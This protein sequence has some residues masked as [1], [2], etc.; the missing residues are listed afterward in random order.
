MQNRATHYRAAA[1]TYFKMGSVDSAYLF[2]NMY[3]DIRDSLYVDG[4]VNHLNELEKKFNSTEKEKQILRLRSEKDR[5]ALVA[6]K[7]QTSN[8]ILV[9]VSVSLLVTGVFYFIYSRRKVRQNLLN[10]QRRLKELEQANELKLTKA[11]LE[12][13]E[14]ERQRVARDLHD[15]LGGMLAG[16]KINLSRENNNLDAAILQLDASVSELRRIARN[17][18]PENLVRMGLYIALQ[19]LC[20]SFISPQ[21]SVEFQ[22]FG[23]VQEMPLLRQMNVYRIAQEILSNAVRH[24]E[25]SEIIVQCSQNNDVLFLTIEDNGKGFEVDNIEK[26]AGMGFGNIKNRVDYLN[27]TMYMDSKLNEGTTINIELNIYE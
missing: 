21:T 23:S 25:A 2:L 9:V 11:M 7:R 4:I 3:A 22:A 20:E 5:A 17:M 18:M 1:T 26:T 8:L 13:E 14:K 16:I 15:G 27:G 10:H 19:D 12:G 6:S 24:A